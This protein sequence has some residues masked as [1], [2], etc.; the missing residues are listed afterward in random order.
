MGPRF[1]Q[2]L[3]YPVRA[4]DMLK[5]RP[6]PFPAGR[7]T[8]T[9][10]PIQALSALSELSWFSLGVFCVFRQGHSDCVRVY[11]FFRMLSFGCSGL[12]VSKRVIDTTDIFV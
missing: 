1:Q 6:D 3:L 5:N 4:P 2:C 9:R 12:V 10:P 8:T 7:M 11:A